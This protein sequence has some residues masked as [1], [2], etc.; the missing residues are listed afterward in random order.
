MPADNFDIMME[1]I[2]RLAVANEWRRTDWHSGGWHGFTQKEI[3]DFNNMVDAA[4]DVGQVIDPYNITGGYVFLD[5]GN[6]SEGL[7]RLYHG[8][9]QQCNPKFWFKI[10]DLNVFSYD[11]A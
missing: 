10:D 5:H 7:I 6:N 9:Q 2:A 8:R 11:Y 4:K 3:R 1:Y